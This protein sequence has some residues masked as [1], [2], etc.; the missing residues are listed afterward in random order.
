MS[1]NISTGIFSINEYQN[2]EIYRCPKCY[3]PQLFHILKRKDVIEVN[4]ECLNGHCYKKTLE[5]ALKEIKS[6]QINDVLC[7]NCSID[8]SHT[9]FF[10]CTKHNN[11]ICESCSYNHLDCRLISFSH[12][13]INCFVHNKY[14]LFFCKKCKKE[15]C[16]ECTNEEHKNHHYFQIEPLHKNFIQEYQ[17][18]IAK[19]EKY[20][21]KF[22]QEYKKLMKQMDE[23][24]NIINNIAGSLIKNY[25]LE[26]YNSK[27]L[28]NAY[29]ELQSK[30]QLSYPIIENVRNFKFKFQSFDIRKQI[31]IKKTIEELTSLFLESNKII[32]SNKEYDNLTSSSLSNSIIE[33]GNFSKKSNSLKSSLSSKVSNKSTYSSDEK[34]EL[35]DNS[36][37][38][39]DKGIKTIDNNKINKPNI[40]NNSFKYRNNLLTS[41][42]NGILITALTISNEGQLITG[43]EKGKIDIYS[44]DKTFI[45]Q[46]SLNPHNKSINY[47]TK[48]NNGKI[49]SCSNDSKYNIVLFSTNNNVTELNSYIMGHEDKVNKVI[50]ISNFNIISCSSDKTIR[51]FEKKGETYKQK[52]I[53]KYDSAVNGIIELNDKEYACTDFYTEKVLFLDNSLKIRQ[54]LDNIKCGSLPTS[55][56]FINNDIFAVGGEGV[57]II[58]ISDKNVI[59]YIDSYYVYM[60]CLFFD[61][62]SKEII[63]GDENGTFSIYNIDNEIYEKIEPKKSHSEVIYS[64]IKSENGIIISSSK[65]I[66]LWG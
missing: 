27:N 22:T 21:N 10:Y 50:E 60:K 12:F 28:I 59:K 53:K 37:K 8:N 52:D 15:I 24:I 26:I 62:D 46:K 5:N 43:N 56:I 11:F 20:F 3:H 47:L 9:P 58:S 55:I 36:T 63:I 31:N 18:N 32:D 17:N 57:Y 29:K 35:I 1:S 41:P 6:N 14:N 45:L 7:S 61:N 66:K 34:K 25:Q 51:I 40:T 19:I 64:I 44:L 49:I 23:D 65:V 38:E 39:S 48:L 4:L 42:N 13:D 30:K 2:N 54:K 16:I 33:S